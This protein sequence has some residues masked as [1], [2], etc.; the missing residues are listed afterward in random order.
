M[1]EEYGYTESNRYKVCAFKHNKLLL[2]LIGRSRIK[3]GSP[4]DGFQVLKHIVSGNWI[5][6]L[7]EVIRFRLDPRGNGVSLSEESL[8]L[9]DS[10]QKEIKREVKMFKKVYK[11]GNKIFHKIWTVFMSG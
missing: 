10:G 3:I 2:E 1:V 6:Y 4:L 7:K 5:N 9:L 8:Y 11:D